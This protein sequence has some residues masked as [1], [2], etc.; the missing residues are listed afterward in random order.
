[1]KKIIFAILTVSILLCGCG[2]VSDQTT[3]NTTFVESDAG[4][5]QSNDYLSFTYENVKNSKGTPSIDAEPVMLKYDNETIYDYVCSTNYLFDDLGNFKS[6][7]HTI[8]NCDLKNCNEMYANIKQQ[9]VTD[10]GTDYEEMS[11]GTSDKINL[12]AWKNSVENITI[13][14]NLT[15]NDTKAELMLMIMKNE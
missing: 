1:M 15:Y 8:I 7:Q 9:L 12:A 13:A 2:N 6:V 11:G 14:L 5:V 10:Y 4:T 3:Q